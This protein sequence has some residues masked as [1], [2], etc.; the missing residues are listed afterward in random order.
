MNRTAPRLMLLDSASMYFRAFHGVPE[1]VVSPDGT[2]VGAVRGFIETPDGER[3]FIRFEG[4][5]RS[6]A[7]L[8][9]Y[10]PVADCPVPSAVQVTG[11]RVALR[12]TAS[13]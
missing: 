3:W 7:G 5:A 13:A 2:P 1:S 4:Y 8:I 12:G 11:R 9:I 6:E 10:D